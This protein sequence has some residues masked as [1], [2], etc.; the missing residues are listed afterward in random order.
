MLQPTTEA[1]YDSG[2]T[3]V[4]LFTPRLP[5]QVD[6]LTNRLDVHSTDG[7]LS[8]DQYNVWQ[9]DNRPRIPSTNSFFSLLKRRLGQ[10][11]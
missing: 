7:A 5:S 8:N 3:L 1:L 11:L 4:S 10:L 9:L 6:V 2:L